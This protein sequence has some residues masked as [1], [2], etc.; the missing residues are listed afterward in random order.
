MKTFGSI[1]NFLN[2]L[3]GRLG[4]SSGDERG[5]QP[6]DGAVIHHSSG[7]ADFDGL[8]GNVPPPAKDPERDLP[9]PPKKAAD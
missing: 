8:P 4:W 1:G 3:L 6:G 2:N 5:P 7:E 9:F